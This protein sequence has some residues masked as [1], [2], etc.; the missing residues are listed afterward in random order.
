MHMLEINDQSINQ[1]KFYETET[2]EHNLM[3]TQGFEL[4]NRNAGFLKPSVDLF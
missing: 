2:N 1:S 3:L 4:G